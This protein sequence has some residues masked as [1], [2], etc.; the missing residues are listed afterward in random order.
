M[1]EIVENGF[2][3]LSP[4]REEGETGEEGDLSLQDIKEAYQ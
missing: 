1:I 3:N 4:K 2:S